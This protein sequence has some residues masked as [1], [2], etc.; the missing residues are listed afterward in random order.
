MG[1]PGLPHTD[2]MFSGLDTMNNLLLFMGCI[3]LCLSI[4][5]YFY[6]K[7]IPLV[8]VVA[9]TA[10][11][12]FGSMIGLA[13]FLTIIKPFLIYIYIA[14]MLA[15]AFGAFVWLK[16]HHINTISDLWTEKEVQDEVSKAKDAAAQ[17]ITHLKDLL[18]KR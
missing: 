15:G 8:H 16:R 14:I 2:G 7:D 1:R 9:G 17:E 11:G 4:G 5:A 3:G 10:L 18:S 13:L 6:V 12:T